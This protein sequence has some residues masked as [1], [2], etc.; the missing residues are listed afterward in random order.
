[1]ISDTEMLDWMDDQ[2]RNGTDTGKCI[3][4]HSNTGRGFR[5]H[6]SSLEGSV[7]SVREAIANAMIEEC[8]NT[9][10]TQ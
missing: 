9:E 2:L 4:R 6:E 7:P 8:L 3:F 10:E 1:M 5:L